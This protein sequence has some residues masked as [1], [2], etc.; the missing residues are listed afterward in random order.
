[1]SDKTKQKKLLRDRGIC[2]IIPT[3][4]NEGTLADVVRRSFQE[5]DDVIVV[6]D[7]STYNVREKLLKTPEATIVSPLNGKTIEAPSGAVGGAS[8]VGLN[9]TIVTHDR[10]RGKGRALSTG[11]QKALELGFSYAITL[12]AD[13]QHYP[14]DIP[15][16]LEANRQHPG[17]LIIGSR[18]MEGKEQSRG[19]RFANRFSNFWFYV[20]TGRRLPD[21]QSGYRLYP[22]GH[23]RLG[24]W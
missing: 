15:L 8:G 12:D 22:L 5:C 3:F 19:S 6:D 20:Q 17:A 9:L 24:E 4:N 2:V 1:M 11:F 13:G 18:R 14:E 23:G 10:N 7:G 21:T 16:F